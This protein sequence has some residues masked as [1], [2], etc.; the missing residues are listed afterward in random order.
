MSGAASL[1]AC[2]DVFPP[3]DVTEAGALARQ[4]LVVL[5]VYRDSVVRDRVSRSRYLA[6]NWVHHR[7]ELLTSGRLGFKTAQLVQITQ[8]SRYLVH[9][10]PSL[11]VGGD[12]VKGK[13]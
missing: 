11:G 5:S 7:F 4:N 1:H 13:G 2:A 10:N 9:L 8:L 6:D 3:A 12:R